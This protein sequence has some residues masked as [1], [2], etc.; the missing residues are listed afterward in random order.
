MSLLLECV[1][2]GSES[3]GI[4]KTAAGAPIDGDGT[5]AGEVG[6]DGFLTGQVDAQN[7]VLPRL[8][9]TGVP[10]GLVDVIAPELDRETGLHGGRSSCEEALKGSR[11][12]L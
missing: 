6:L 4:E 1:K 10:D 5:S 7:L 11:Q 2:R 8:G 12:F 9:R 3:V